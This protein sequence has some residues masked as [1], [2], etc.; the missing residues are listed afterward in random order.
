MTTQ[1]KS[2]PKLQAQHSA[3]G[4]AS[5]RKR[6]ARDHSE[7]EKRFTDVPKTTDRTLM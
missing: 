6:L 5:F 1:E 3:P 2:T 4:C 7:N